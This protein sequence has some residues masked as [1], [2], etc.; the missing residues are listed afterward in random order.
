MKMWRPD[1]KVIGPLLADEDDIGVLNRIFSDAFTDRYRRDGMVGVRVPALN[2]AIWRYALRDAGTGAMVWRDEEDGLVAFNIAHHSGLEGWMGPLAVRPDRQRLGLGGAIVRSAIEWLQEQRVTTLGLETMPRT[3]DNIGFYSRLD[4]L[5]GHLTVTMG[6]D[7]V[8][9]QPRERG[10]RL[11]RLDASERADL[12]SRCVSRLQQSAPGYDFTREHELTNELEIGDT[13]VVERGGEIGAFAIWHSVPLA[14]SRVAEEVRIL[15]LFADS[16]A[17]FLALI[18]DVEASAARLSIR[19]VTVRCQSGYRD[20]FRELVARGYD[21]RWT[22]LR[23]TLA[24]HA[25]AEVPE[26]ETLFSNWEI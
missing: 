3:V 20:A 11:S 1:R 2:P 15:K 13:T 24:G 22:D 21:V 10:I 19:R 25:E 9:R 6:G 17:S 7:V 4:F 23:M 16:R 26:G 14:D 5:P 18:R 8:S 12:I